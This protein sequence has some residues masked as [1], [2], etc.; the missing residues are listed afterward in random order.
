MMRIHEELQD[1]HLTNCT[2]LAAIGFAAYLVKPTRQAELLTCLATVLAPRPAPGSR[3][4]IASANKAD[5]FAGR[6]TR[7]LLAEDNR[8]N[9]MVAVAMLKNMGLRADVV[10]N[11][12]EAVKAL[13]TLPYDLV[14]MDVQM[15]EMDGITATKEVRSPQSRALN[16]RIPIIAMTAGAMANDR[17]NCLNAGMDDFIAKP[18]SVQTFADTL[19][20][21]LPNA[22]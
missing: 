22:V 7:I 5:R 11:G 17:A 13:E 21:W 1:G 14:L 18:V 12:Q 9:Q 19:T 15:P 10:A 4:A 2:K 16:P 8:T 6:R 20:R 3:P